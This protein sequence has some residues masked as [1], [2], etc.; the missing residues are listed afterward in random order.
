[1]DELIIVY[2]G[3][4]FITGRW[5]YLDSVL[6]WIDAAIIGLIW[7]FAMVGL[8]VAWVDENG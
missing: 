7:P 3:I 8:F 4:A 5:Y 1:M 2:A 6:P